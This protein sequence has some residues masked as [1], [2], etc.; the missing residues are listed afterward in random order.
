[1]YADV[2]LLGDANADG[3]VNVVDI[4]EIVTA[5]LGT[6]EA[7]QE[8]MSQYNVD[9]TGDGILNVVDI[10]AMVNQILEGDV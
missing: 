4:V 9:L 3:F 10:I 6:P 8:F 2:N 1:M 5:I 7:Q